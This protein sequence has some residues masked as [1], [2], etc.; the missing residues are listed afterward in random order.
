MGVGVGEL[1]KVFYL[2][3]DAGGIHCAAS[4]DSVSLS[5]SQRFYGKVLSNS[6]AGD[7]KELCFTS[8]FPAHTSECRAL[9]RGLYLSLFP[10]VVFTFEKHGCPHNR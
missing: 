9:T 3:T 6:Y 7:K 10:T 4:S 2:A 5:V 8:C 1:R